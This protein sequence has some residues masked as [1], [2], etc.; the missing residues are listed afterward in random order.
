MRTLILC[1][2][3]IGLVAGPMAGNVSH[4]A[5]GKRVALVVGNA[6]YEN[7]TP[8]ANP[9][10]D[11]QAI[12][13]ALRR[14]G[15]V[16]IEAVDQDKTGMQLL[17]REFARELQDADTS[18]FFYAGHGLQVQRRNYLVPIDATLESEVDLPF[19]AVAVDVVLDLM[20]QTTPQRLVFLDACRDNPLARRLARS[21]GKTRSLGVG[22]GLA[23]MNNRVG[24]LIAFAT[25]PD[26]V[27]LDGDDG[28]S[29][30][31]SALLEHIETPGIEIRQ[32]LSRV[33]GTVI[34]NTGGEQLPLDT[35]ALVDDFYFSVP[36]QEP[37][38]QVAAIPEPPAPAPVAPAP[39]APVLS[40]NSTEHLFW[41]TIQSSSDPNDF[42]AY[43]SRY[44]EGA[45][46]S[47]A[48]N[49]LAV[50]G[51]AQQDT[52]VA[53]LNPTQ[54]ILPAPEPAPQAVP[55]PAPQTVPA[56]PEPAPEPVV[57]VDPFD[58]TMVATRNVNVRRDPNTDRDP[59]GVVRQGNQVAVV[60][61]VIG[62]N[63][64][65][66]KRPDGEGEAY[67]YAPLFEPP[68]PVVA[69]APE[70][71]SP[72]PAPVVQAAPKA[73][74]AQTAK[75][76]AQPVQVASVAPGVVSSPKE[77]VTRATV[78]APQ[79][80]TAALTRTI[81]ERRRNAMLR[82]NYRNRGQVGSD[83]IP[84]DRWSDEDPHDEGPRWAFADASQ[85]KLESSGAAYGMAM[86][87]IQVTPEMFGVLMFSHATYGGRATF[88]TQ[89]AADALKQ[90][91]FLTEH[92]AKV[93]SKASLVFDGVQFEVAALALAPGAPASSCFGF[94]AIKVNKRADG[95]VCKTQGAPYEAS[96]AN[97]VLQQ[98]YV[99]RL[100]EP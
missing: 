24:T 43:L 74:P 21:T 68:A 67:V 27:A 65:R 25:E 29:P 50:L 4:A 90:W 64:Y 87:A 59:V 19:E 34:D 70:P 52:E 100:I 48:R 58:A 56:T 46:A 15:F 45:F 71:A 85:T 23:R 30:F 28:H 81:G 11:G 89:R 75:V 10:N 31:T 16:V 86:R 82:F 94:V 78:P 73:A 12:A 42:L 5:V 3:L 76:P 7:A 98:V 96:Q 62:A 40:D 6:A 20:E 69:K 22:R 26:K 99:P 18:L 37:E 47:L 2:V 55:Q 33:R 38:P 41:N 93:T 80:D 60:G 32:M 61:K 44:P 36:Q 35:S 13:A 8:L 53:A 97:A 57:E 1:T 77:P 72:E 17:L 92:R 14:L 88:A 63:W 95:F 54:P 66:I 51:A 49:R 39:A 84:F 91:N 83:Y 79:I 9:V